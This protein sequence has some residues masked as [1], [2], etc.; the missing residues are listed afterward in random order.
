MMRYFCC[1]LLLVLATIKHANAETIAER[2]PTLPAVVV[3]ANDAKQ[4]ESFYILHSTIISP[5]RRLALVIAVPA[6]ALNKPDEELIKISDLALGTAK[7]V[8]VGDKVGQATVM[9]IE[10][11]AIVLSWSGRK[12]TIYLFEHR[13]MEKHT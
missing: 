9:S 7:Y 8:A 6:D 2:D 13:G 1:I 11:S 10:K 5:T 3:P 12:Q 4:E